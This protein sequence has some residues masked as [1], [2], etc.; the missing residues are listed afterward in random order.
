[1]LIQRQNSNIK[2][3]DQWKRGGPQPILTPQEVK[4]LSRAT[5]VRIRPVK[6]GKPK[7][8]K[9]HFIYAYARIYKNGKR[10]EKYIGRCPVQH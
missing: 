9:L 4:T 2:P 1:M 8:K 7:C 10:T 3:A 6:C 5:G